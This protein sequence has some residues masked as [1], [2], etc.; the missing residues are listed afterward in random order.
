[1][2]YPELLIYFLIETKLRKLIDYKE[3]SE[4]QRKIIYNKI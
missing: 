1:M 2:I 4:Y 3:R